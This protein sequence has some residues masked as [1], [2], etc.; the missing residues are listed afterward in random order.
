MKTK[1]ITKI[2]LLASGLF[3]T[4]LMAET[5]QAEKH[6]A[7]CV[8]CHLAEGQGIP[9]AFPPLKNRLAKMSNSEL[10]RQ[11]V[12]QV[13]YGGLMGMITVEGQNY[14]G[15]MPA[16]TGDLSAKEVSELLNYAVNK[17][18]KNGKPENWKPFS[19]KE[20][21]RL[22]KTKGNPVSNGNL[23]KQLLENQRDLK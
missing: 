9:G 20:V 4:P 23:R 5:D 14:S 11:Y 18:D 15:V 17:V 12:V 10:G 2:A 1:R 16:Q 21:E 7:R 13:L 6:F 8:A 22:S 3:C 19:E